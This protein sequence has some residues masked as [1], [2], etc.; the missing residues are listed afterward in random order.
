MPPGRLWGTRETPRA[1]RSTSRT[2]CP[3]RPRRRG[4]V[5]I[6][7]PAPVPFHRT[8]EHGALSPH[9]GTRHAFTGLWNTPRFHRTVEHAAFHRTVE[10]DPARPPLSAAGRAVV[11]SPVVV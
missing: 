8:V 4:S 9:C 2:R 3:L 1:A 11:K 5:A 6:A 7:R 10:H